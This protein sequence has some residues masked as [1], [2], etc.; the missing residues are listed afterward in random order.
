MGGRRK[1]DTSPMYAHMC[2]LEPPIIA[3]PHL[4]VIGLEFMELS[5]SIKY[6][7]EDVPR[8][9]I[10]MSRHPRQPVKI[11]FERPPERIS[12]NKHTG[13]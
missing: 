7:Q 12:K 10:V 5:V 4:F 8:E 13:L 3:V 9:V 1:D 6:L 2:E 11:T